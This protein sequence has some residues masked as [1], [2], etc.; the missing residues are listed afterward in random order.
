MLGQ[1]WESVTR[2]G[3][4]RLAPDTS[5]LPSSLRSRPVAPLAPPLLFDHIVCNP[6]DS[7][8]PIIVRP[9]AQSRQCASSWLLSTS[10]PRVGVAAPPL[11]ST[12]RPVISQVRNTTWHP[13]SLQCPSHFPY[14]INHSV[15]PWQCHVSCILATAI[16]EHS[17][18]GR[19]A[20]LRTEE[21]LLADRGTGW[22]K[23]LE[24]DCVWPQTLKLILDL[25]TT[26]CHWRALPAADT[27]SRTLRMA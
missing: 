17:Y 6:L 14:T 8:P 5:G 4:C 3:G 1:R 18:L 26:V 7:H 16:C 21:Q 10:P 13:R 25:A 27:L 22:N 19:R 11:S 9:P 12:R 15:S 24:C 20:R 2:V 23:S